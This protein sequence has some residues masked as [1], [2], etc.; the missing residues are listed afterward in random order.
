MKLKRSLRTGFSFGL[1]SGIIT[2]LGLMIGLSAGTHSQA[3][4]IGGV[5]TIAIADSLSDSLGIHI[6]EEAKKASDRSVWESTI[7]AF[8]TKFFFALS[9]VIPLMVFDLD[10]AI[11]LAIAWGLSLLALFSYVIA[12]EKE[13]PAWKVI[14]EHLLIAIIVIMAT[15]VIGDIIG[16]H[17]GTG[18]LVH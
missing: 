16:T 15:N 17:F 1:T 10:F 14:G 5:I 12:L 8:V 9:F 2:T 11:V 6:S 7:S 18:S 4:V 3:V 13:V